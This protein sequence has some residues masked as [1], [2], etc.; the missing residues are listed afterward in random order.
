M[1]AI[2][3]IF[4]GSLANGYH[5][6]QFL[7]NGDQRAYINPKLPVSDSFLS[8]VKHEITKQKQGWFDHSS[9]LL[10]TFMVLGNEHGHIV[11]L[12]TISAQE[13]LKELVRAED[14]KF[15]QALKLATSVE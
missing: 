9:S 6:G 4:K 14:A 2:P 12:V 11:D 1:L 10:E 8:M 13:V 3:S 15:N 5:I 7:V